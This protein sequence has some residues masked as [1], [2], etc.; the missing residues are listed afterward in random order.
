M[1][2][3]NVTIKYI[4]S[5]YSKLVQKEYKT[6]HLHFDLWKKFKFDQTNLWY[7]YHI[8]GEWKAQ[9]SLGL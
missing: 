3:S 7:M 8:P 5:E 9:T 1:W 6:R 4:I 2:W